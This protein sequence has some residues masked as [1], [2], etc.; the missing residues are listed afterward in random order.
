MLPSN[1]STIR[2]R[3]LCYARGGQRSG[4][5]GRERGICRARVRGL[6][7]GGQSVEKRRRHDIIMIQCMDGPQMKG[8]PE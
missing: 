7:R 6:G 4:R 5:R 8:Q 3:K 1:T 2:V